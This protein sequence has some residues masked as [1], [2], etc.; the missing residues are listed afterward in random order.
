MKIILYGV[1]LFQFLAILLS[2]HAIADEEDKVYHSMA[3]LLISECIDD[4]NANLIEEINKLGADK[5]INSITYCVSQTFYLFILR[6]ELNEQNNFN[7]SYRL[8]IGRLIAK[9]G[10]DN[11]EKIIRKGYAIDGKNDE[12]IR[13]GIAFFGDN[14]PTVESLE[15]SLINYLALEK[16]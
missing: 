14:K 12:T 2:N 16:K 11:I 15:K 7:K 1:L 8:Q 9:V 6:D 10:K 5:V 3:I 4:K 13:I